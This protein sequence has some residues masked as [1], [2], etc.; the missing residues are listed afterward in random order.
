VNSGHQTAGREKKKPKCVQNAA[1]NISPE[2]G[3]ILYRIIKYHQ[4]RVLY[5][6]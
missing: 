3:D 5:I 6:P 1:P 2:H 4:K